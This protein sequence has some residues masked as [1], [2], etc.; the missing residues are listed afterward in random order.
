MPTY[1]S[2]TDIT[3]TTA[4]TH[5]WSLGIG[6]T[7]IVGADAMIAATGAT[8]HG[9]NGTSNATVILQG[10][11]IAS[12]HGIALT[13]SAEVRIGADGSIAVAEDGV[14]IAGAAG[15]VLN[16]GEIMAGGY[17]VFFADLGT[18]WRQVAQ[19]NG[20]ISGATGIAGNGALEV[21]NTGTIQATGDAGA[22]PSFGTAVHAWRD[23][24]IDN[25]GSI[26][27]SH[28]AGIDVGDGGGQAIIR[29][30]G[31]IQASAG[32]N[33]VSTD[34]G[35]DY[36]EN[37]GD[38]IGTVSLGNGDNI[39]DGSAGRILGGITAGSGSDTVLGGSG[40]EAV[41]AGAGDDE[42]ATGGGNDSVQGNAGNDTIDAG[43][44]NDIVDGGHGLDSMEGGAGF[45]ILSYAP[46]FGAV[47]VNLAT[48]EGSGG[49]AEGDV[50]S[51]FEG[52]RGS[53]H[54]DTLTG[55]TGNDLLA[56]LDGED[57]LVG[58]HGN[59]RLLGGAG[60]DMMQGGVGAD[61]LRGGLGADS[62]RYVN[63]AESTVAGKGR[64]RIMD[65]NQAELDQI[66]LWN[67]DANS[68]VAGNQAFS[69]VGTAAFSN[70]A[71]EL[72]YVSGPMATMVFGDVNGDG[73]ADF[74]I[75]LSGAFALTAADFVL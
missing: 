5:G 74:A 45:D 43:D 34:S 21:V 37:A 35:N 12:Q 2:N 47:D 26:V 59:D 1:V 16:N 42:V 46:S 60:N 68:G 54:A 24:I 3:R 25:A 48:G 18:T 10:D 66:N 13:S 57:L 55:S 8:S 72:R 27:S 28:G 73:A 15:E 23:A 63:V 75:Q 4:S 31:L 53:L 65:F 6:D 64:D 56:G 33:A 69:F 30:T 29:N 36:V 32:R 52:V 40:R 7:L 50:F 22:V 44:G 41:D 71:G 38:I 70:T 61:F 20:T 67:I 51:G 58:S 9:V 62:F 11:I 39:Y 17:G 49:I 14:R 19:N